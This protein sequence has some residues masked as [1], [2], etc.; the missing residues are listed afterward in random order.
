MH[1]HL[2]TRQIPCAGI[3]DGKPVH[4]PKRVSGPHKK[5][6]QSSCASICL[7]WENVLVRNYLEIVNR[8]YTGESLSK[9]EW[10]F[11]IIDKVRS[12][13]EKY[14]LTWNKSE[15][16][17]DNG[18]LPDR[19]FKAGLELIEDIGVY[20]ISE[21]RVIALSKREIFE[22]IQR[23][24]RTLSLG[25]GKDRYD[26][27]P[28]GICDE[29]PPAVWAGNPGV[30]TPERLFKATVKSWTQEPIVDLITCGSI[31]E[32]DGFP[33]RSGSVAELVASRREL[34]YLKQVREETG[35][36]GIGMLAAESSVTEIGD[37]AAAHPNLLRSCDAHL[38]AMFNELM[39]DEGNM[40]RAANSL[41]YGM[42]N[43]SLAT[44]MVGGLAGDA[45]GAAVVQAASFS[46]REYCLSC[47]LP[48][49]SSHSYS[50]CRHFHAGMPLAS[51]YCVSGL[52]QERSW[53]NRRRH[54]S[55]KRRHDK[56]AAVRGCSKRHRDYRQRWAPR[57]RRIR[58]R[59]F[60][61]RNRA[62][63][64]IDG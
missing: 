37:L 22:G 19:V 45:P 1:S 55:E 13:V 11:R 15:I 12:L 64:P 32:V 61:P 52:R 3:E 39:I 36:P 29:R 31:V 40:I 34:T 38:V 8:S 51:K 62:G 60:A 10:D 20:N 6:E 28:R 54:L 16:C 49:L 5:T 23:M 4:T 17:P 7:W 30:P 41:Y 47:R 2:S 35:R 57:R 43:A 44:V 26:L 14:S 50:S 42:A 48:S 33:V 21:K 24:N 25:E 27:S 56:R 9:E 63:S 18:D 59:R 58:R 53:N 46:G